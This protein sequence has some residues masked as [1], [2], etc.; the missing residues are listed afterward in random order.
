M[1]SGNA[2]S[3]TSNT[4]SAINFA[5][6]SGTGMV[7]STTS[8]IG[9]NA[10]GGGS[11]SVTGSNNTISST[12]GI[13]LNVVNTAIGASGLTFRSISSNGA[14]SGIVLN[15]T[16]SGGLTVTGGGSAGSGGTIR[17]GV[18]G[19]SLTSAQNVSL[20]WMQLNDFSDFAI[21]GSSVVNFTMASTVINGA[22]G[23][24]AGFFEGSVRFTELTGS[25]SVT[26]SSISGGLVDNF[27]VVNTSG[28]LNRITFDTVTIGANSV[29]S[30]SDG[31]LIEGQN[32]AVVNTTVQNS[33]FTSTR[34]DHF[35]LNLIGTASSNL[36]FTGNNI[37]NSH[38]AVVSG[39]GGIRLTGGSTGGNVTATYNISSNTIRDSNGTAIGVT[40]GAGTGSFSGTINGNTIGVAATNGSGSAAG[41][42]ISV[43]SAEG[44]SS[45]TAITNNTVRQYANFG[46]IVQAGGLPTVG[47]GTLDAVVTGN[48]I[49][50][51]STAIFAKNGFQ[52]NSG[53]VPGDAFNVCLS[54]GGAGA[55]ANSLA[56]SGTDGGTDFRLR[57]RQSTTVRLPGYGGA[58]NNDAAVITFGQGNNGVTPTGSATNTVPTGG[59]WTGGAAC[60]TAY[61]MQPNDSLAAEEDAPIVVASTELTKQTFADTLRNAAFHN[62]ASGKV[63]LSVQPALSSYETRRVSHLKF[64][65]PQAARLS[66]TN[67]GGAL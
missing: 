9:F 57:Q 48:T 26:N 23:D 12:T 46:I 1:T 41:S 65:H 8:G 52:L 6:G 37:S 55:L 20:S 14:S 51:P 56:G 33:F 17:N 62:T 43:I 50:N 30:G 34:G 19:I 21:R 18:T 15:T 5:T 22:S 28:T 49:S 61:A 31:I 16:G 36:I 4:G 40:K 2:V 42:G 47:T 13:A 39:G 10:T 3:L 63:L 24:N 66:S 35:Q 25:A 59:G 64:P 54:F 27:N 38:P 58:N 53:T 60:A 32:A 44:G 45:V 29:S 11:V 7:L 67:L